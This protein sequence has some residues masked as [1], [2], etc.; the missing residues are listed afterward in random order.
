MLPS[1]QLGVD[2]SE[3]LGK[4]VMAEGRFLQAPSNIEAEIPAVSPIPDVEKLPL[5]RDG[6]DEVKNFEASGGEP[7]KQT[8]SIPQAITG[9]LAKTLSRVRTKDSID[10]GPPPD[11]GLQAWSMACLAHLVIFNT[12]GFINS[13]GLFQTYYVEVMKIGGPSSVA[14]IGTTQIFILFGM[15]TFTGRGLDAGFFR[16]QFIIG[17][18]IY[19]LGM[20]LLS[21]CQ[22]YWQIFL[23][24]T[25]CVGIGFGLVF[26][27]SLA[28]VSTY[29]LKRRSTGLGI[30]VT[31]S[32]TG[33]LVF[34][35][36]A[37]KML[38]SVGFPW[39]VRTMAF[40][41]LTLAIISGAFL[42]VS[43]ASS[44]S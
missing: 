18:A 14:W 13:F 25:V 34:P 40:V 4:L 44:V 43:G 41:Q 7:L 38:P 39:T 8:P 3:I 33:G 28:L 29:F 5:D 11:G 12:W 16:L 20:F 31:G 2:V 9:A 32:A 6:E 24:Q 37:E 10:P 30:A 1:F 19:V 36:I 27:P 17:S 21:L 22:N 23:A 15:G 26:V 35:A 42:K